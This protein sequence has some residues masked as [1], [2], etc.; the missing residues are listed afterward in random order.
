[1]PGGLYVPSGRAFDRVNHA[2]LTYARFGLQFG[3]RIIHDR[4]GES[5]AASRE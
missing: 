1:L 2:W 3:R 4:K 5:T